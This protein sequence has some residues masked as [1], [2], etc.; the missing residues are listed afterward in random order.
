[1]SVRMSAKEEKERYKSQKSRH[2]HYVGH[3]M[4]HVR[5]KAQKCTFVSELNLQQLVFVAKLLVLQKEIPI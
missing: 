2:S 1:M 4:K 5:N 3:K